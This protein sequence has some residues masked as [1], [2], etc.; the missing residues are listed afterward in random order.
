MPRAG[1]AALQDVT[2]ELHMGGPS[3]F[4]AQPQKSIVE[5][6]ADGDVVMAE[7]REVP[8]QP[9]FRVPNGTQS[10][11]EGVLS[12]VQ[13]IVPIP[14]PMQPAV[15]MELSRMRSTSPVFF[16]I[17]ARN[18]N[19][20]Q[21]ATEYIEDIMNFQ[22]SSELR[23]RPASHYMERLQTDVNPSMRAILVDWLNEVA[24]EYHLKTET[25]HLAVNLIDRFLSSYVVNRSRL[26][27]VGV[28]G[29]LIASKY[30]EIMPPTVDEF[31]YITDNTYNRDDLLKLEGVMLNTLRFE[32][33]AV[34]I[35]DFLPRFL[36]AANADHR[37][38]YLAHYIVELTLQDYHF[39]N[40][41]P[42]MMA[43]SAVALALHTVG[44]PAWS[45]TLQ[46]YTRYSPSDIRTC[47]AELHTALRNA[48]VQSL[49]AVREKFAHSRYMRV[50][51]MPCPTTLPNLFL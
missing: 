50:S 44:L 37:L 45:P 41:L 12:M 4:H 18:A 46:Y 48:E 51:A 43:A 33:T 2:N 30:E 11:A 3:K 16:N 6:T 1:R 19:D 5:T 47:V 35:A 39:L 49:Q 17:D 24:Q 8:E 34:T 40:F 42:S 26:Q 36:L 7:S 29:M 9:Q 38:A 15:S 25:L 27:L 21:F 20:P 10:G 13:P 32:I 31:V 23:H 28:T 14:Q 22:R